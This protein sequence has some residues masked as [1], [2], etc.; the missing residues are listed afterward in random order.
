M[1]VMQ[2][3][4]SLL[5][6]FLSSNASTVVMFGVTLVLARLLSPADIGVFSI[7]VVFIN[8]V[9]VFRDFGINAYLVREQH[10]TPAKIRSA[11]G[12]VLVLSW[13]LATGVYLGAKPFAAFY[14]QPGI[15]DVLHVLT[16][17]FLLVPYASVL[18]ALL[19]RNMEAGKS[20]FVVTVST[21]VYSC[22]CITLALL[23]FSYM[24]MAWANVANL[25]TNIACLLYVRPKDV[26]LLPSFKG[27]RAP[28]Q[29]G[30][31][32]ILG[33]L[34]ITTNNSVPDLI[35]GKMGGVHE[36]GLYS[37][38]NG[39]VGIFQ[40]VAGPA[41]K[42]NALPFIAKNHHVNEPL[43]PLL[44]T[45]TSYLTGLAW[46]AFAGVA[47][48]A[49]DVITTLYGAQWLGAA[50]LV[51]VLCTSAALQMG[52]SLA[53]P[54]LVA[55][56]RPYLAALASGA[57]FLARLLCIA[58]V[59]LGSGGSPSLMQFALAICIADIISLPVPAWLMAKHLGYS[60]KESLGA[61]V[62]SLKV[63]VLC[64]LSAL[65]LKALLPED[66]PAFVHLLCAAM[67][68]GSVW[69]VALRYFKHPL[70]TEIKRIFNA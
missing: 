62:A 68:V 24:A 33:N 20:A 10:L 4:K 1:V 30:S 44:T 7:A 45:S 14:G 38:A 50:P 9:A 42:Y 2:L 36:V 3:R 26:V 53:Q 65:L 18:S 54:A 63:W 15:A 58:L 27:W 19:M 40:Q 21:V 12:L 61:H 17:S 8:I 66:W 56:G 60:L 34:I 69:L 25:L 55:I 32:D 70:N 16:L 22:T 39:L 41:V 47:V 51:A 67:V 52:Y 23:D 31:G 6:T 11:L 48:Y 57:H 43:S 29:F 35:L 46:P 49:D 64:L 59:A 13:V 28:I 5:I 37:R